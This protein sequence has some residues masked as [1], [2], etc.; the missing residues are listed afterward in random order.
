M[1]V[2]QLSPLVGYIYRIACSGADGPTDGQLLE[3]YVLRNNKDAFAGLVRRHGAMVHGVCSRVLGNCHDA[4]DAYQATFLVLMRKG[5]KMVHHD[6]IG[7]WL[8]LVA[9]RT[10]LKA[11]SA[12]LRRRLIEKQAATSTTAEIVPEAVW[13]ELRPILDQEIAQLPDKYRL[14]FVLCY[15]EGKTN[16]Q[17][18]RLLRWPLGTVATQLARAR[19][20]LRKR[21]TRR[22]ATLAVGLLSATASRTAF[23]ASA[24]SWGGYSTIGIGTRLAA[25]KLASGGTVSVRAAALAKGVLG[26]MWM[27]KLRSAALMLAAVVAMVG[28]SGVYLC[29]AGNGDEG[30]GQG[31][32][33]VVPPPARAGKDATK[34]VAQ[35]SPRNG[36]SELISKVYS[37]NDLLVF[38][39][40]DPK[41]TGIAEREDPCV[42][43]RLTERIMEIAPETWSDAGGKATVQYYPLG[44]AFVITQSAANHEKI[45]AL[46]ES[47]R[48]E[49][50]EIVIE[51]RW[52]RLPPAKAELFLKSAEFQQHSATEPPTI[53]AQ[54]AFLKEPQFLRWFEL[55]Q[56]DPA[57]YFWNAPKATVLDGQKVDISIG[58]ELSLGLEKV[59]LGFRSNFLP[60]VS[61]DRRFVRMRLTWQKTDLEK[62]SKLQTNVRML[63]FEA[64]VVIPSSGTAV[65]YLGTNEEKQGTFAMVTTRV[66]TK[67][68]PKEPEAR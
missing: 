24:S 37:V 2:E 13:Q 55:F 41:T 61:A 68:P 39:C 4:D 25:T 49:G 6:C 48:E 62:P 51:A 10:A 7:G 5:P 20:R 53:L 17:A 59:F 67:A 33:Q 65:W 19:D 64:N 21:L 36:E 29:G 44:K 14:P 50:L 3:Q 47:M 66:I 58:E 46:L 57:S 16:S 12:A 1:A 60:I 31:A 52:V 18:A 26:A 56:S 54:V 22:G 30:G 11:R 34:D 43:Q 63:A 15:L 38:I 45:N 23:A 28:G 8:H 40:D 35:I 32:T 27:T 42:L 9:Y